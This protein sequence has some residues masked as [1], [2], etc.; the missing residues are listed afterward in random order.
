[1]RFKSRFDCRCSISRGNSQKKH[2]ECKH[3]FKCLQFLQMNEIHLICK[4]NTGHSLP[5]R[6][7]EMIVPTAIRSETQRLQ[8]KL[9]LNTLVLL[10]NLHQRHDFLG[11][12]ETVR[13]KRGHLRGG[14]CVCLDTVRSR[15]LGINDGTH[16]VE[17]K[18]SKQ[19]GKIDYLQTFFKSTTR[20]ELSCIRIRE[21]LL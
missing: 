12:H 2:K 8:C 17:L 1:M 15:H 4:G 18:V 10:G 9:K 16:G 3:Y 14:N 6:S 20:F 21:R 11:S 19:P 5:L 7:N 13:H